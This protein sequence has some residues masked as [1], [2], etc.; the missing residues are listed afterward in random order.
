MSLP[1]AQAGRILGCVAEAVTQLAE[2]RPVRA[3][4]HTAL[5]GGKSAQLAGGVP[6]GA[7][8]YL[9]DVAVAHSLLLPQARKEGRTDGQAGALVPG[10]AAC[11]VGCH[12]RCLCPLT[13]PDCSARCPGCSALWLCTTEGRAQRTPLWRPAS[14]HWW[15][16]VQ[17]RRAAARPAW[18]RPRLV[19]ASTER[20]AVFQAGLAHI[21]VRPVVRQRPSP[22]LPS[23]LCRWCHACPPATSP[24]GVT[25]SPG[26]TW[27][28][29]GSTYASSPPRGWLR[30]WRRGWPVWTSSP[31]EWEARRGSGRP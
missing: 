17:R 3:V 11:S 22:A 25:C 6:P 1:S 31:G 12:R 14:P 24:S 15:V 2:R 30:G 21:A 9:L 23:L 20:L 28:P 16:G 8:Y 27:G 18:Q 5:G 26:A 13:S 19:L 29:A 10:C 4:I 7:P